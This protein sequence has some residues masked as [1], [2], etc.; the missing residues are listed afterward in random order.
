[1]IFSCFGSFYSDE[2]SDDDEL[3]ECFLFLFLDFYFDIIVPSS[4]FI[5]CSGTIYSCLTGSSNCLFDFFFLE[6]DSDL[7][8]SIFCFLDSVDLDNFCFLFFFSSL[9]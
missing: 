4:I 9:L 2:D 7:D 3:L 6:F 1:M 5:V 8:L